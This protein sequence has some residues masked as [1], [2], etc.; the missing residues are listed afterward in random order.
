MAKH[1][2]RLRTSINWIL[3]YS[4]GH[5]VISIGFPSQ[6][7][8]YTNAGWLG[9]PSSWMFIM[10]LL[11]KSLP[12]KKNSHH[13]QYHIHLYL[14]TTESC[15]I[16]LYLLI[17]DESCSIMLY[18][19][20]SVEAWTWL[21]PLMFFFSTSATDRRLPFPNVGFGLRLLWPEG[22]VNPR[23][24]QMGLRDPRCYG[25]VIGVPPVIIHL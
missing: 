20:V 3:F 16:H 5:L 19:L 25:R 9:I 8:P 18:P 22:P 13:L 11:R 21:N 7:G 10:A 1:M 4:H 6:L 24:R 17:T 12:T 14:L 2:V 15:Y 23:P